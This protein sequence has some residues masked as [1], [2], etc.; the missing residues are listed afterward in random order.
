MLL[1]YYLQQYANNIQ[2]T[3]LEHKALHN[4]PAAASQLI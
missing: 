2:D 1:L 4:V 3:F